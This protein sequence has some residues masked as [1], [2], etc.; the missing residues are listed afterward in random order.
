MPE[1]CLFYDSS[2]K[3]SG[4]EIFLVA[5]APLSITKH[6]RVDSFPSNYIGKHFSEVLKFK[7]RQIVSTHTRY[8]IISAHA[9]LQQ[10]IADLPGEY[11]RTL[12]LVV[13]DLVDDLL[14]GNARL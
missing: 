8:I 5:C 7:G 13:G 3:R 9:F 2:E 10:S 11:R 6:T 1:N 14:G 12:A 4:E